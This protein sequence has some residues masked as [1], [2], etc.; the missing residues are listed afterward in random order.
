[1]MCHQMETFP[2]YWPIV[3]GIHRPPVNSPH[4]GQWCEALI[5]SL[6]CV[7]INGCVNNREA[8]DFRR[9]WALYDVIVMHWHWISWSIYFWVMVC[10]VFRTETLPEPL[11]KCS[12]LDTV[13]RNLIE[14]KMFFNENRF[15]Y[16][17]CKMLIILFSPR[18]IEGQIGRK[19]KVINTRLSCLKQIQGLLLSL[20]F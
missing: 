20:L 6:I 9:Y 5:F 2:R 18:Y 19:W 10:R 12:H 13:E 16:A 7:W 8:D 15:E 11:P 3:R 1:M 17:F 4:K 14:P